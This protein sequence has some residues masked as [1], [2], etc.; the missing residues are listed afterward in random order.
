MKGKTYNNAAC[1]FDIF[2]DI[3][4]NAGEVFMTKRDILSLAIKTI[5][6]IAVMWAILHIPTVGLGISVLLQEP[7][8]VFP[9]HHAFFHF[10]STITTLVL[11]LI[12]A[13]VLL[14]WSDSIARWVVRQDST[15]TISGHAGWEKRIFTVALRVVGVVFLVYGIPKLAELVE[16]L[17]AGWGNS[18][19]DAFFYPYY[20]TGITSALIRIILGFYLLFDGRLFVDAAFRKQKEQHA[21]DEENQVKQ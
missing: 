8:D 10:M 21:S 3:S 12:M 20:P 9:R 1:H 5:G 17:L 14:R 6:I 13:Y 18:G 2:S 15:L 7:S 4:Y 16:Q 19:F 11:L